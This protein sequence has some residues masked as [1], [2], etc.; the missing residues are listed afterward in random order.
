QA[1]QKR[2]PAPRSGT[3]VADPPA[4]APRSA[5]EQRMALRRQLNALVAAY[6][7]RTGLP[8]GKI[9]AELRR[10]CG[11][12]P[13][14]Q[15]TI[16]QLRDRIAAIRELRRAGPARSGGRA[17]EADTRP[18]ARATARAPGLTSTAREGQFWE[19]SAAPRQVKPGSVTYRTV[20]LAS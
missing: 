14:A 17:P 16:E 10:R 11:G 6:H 18:G 3:S 1:S 9:H 13:S 2:T 7:H 5:A 20:I 19:S 12:P 15:A 4:P 8:H